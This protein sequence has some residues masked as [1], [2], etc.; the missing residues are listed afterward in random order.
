MP[1]PCAAR[2]KNEVRLQLP[3]P[4]IASD[5]I[6]VLADARAQDPQARIVLDCGGAAELPCRVVAELSRL[7]GELRRDGGDLV[8]LNCDGSVRQAL[9]N[10]PPA[11]PFG[12]TFVR[13]A[14]HRLRGPHP[15]FLRTFQAGA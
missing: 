13:H 1:T 3:T 15:A 10:P 14:A 8:L 6:A 7:R 5:L 11:S 9:D 2:G 4:A 12:G